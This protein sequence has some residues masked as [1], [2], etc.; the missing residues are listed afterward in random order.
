M[1][2]DYEIEFYKSEIERLKLELERERNNKQLPQDVMNE[3]QEI[4]QI[5]SEMRSLLN[6]CRYE[7]INMNLAKKIDNILKRAA[8]MD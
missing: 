5:A 8:Y 3:V 2:A 7:Q 4:V 6:E 1:K